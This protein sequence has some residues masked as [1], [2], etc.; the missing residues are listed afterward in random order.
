M[1][2]IWYETVGGNRPDIV[3]LNKFTYF[4]L[5]CPADQRFFPKRADGEQTVFIEAGLPCP[6]SYNKGTKNIFFGSWQETGDELDRI[7][8]LLGVGVTR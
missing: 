8:G 5:I 3:D 1:D 6:D 4:R 7:K 2:P